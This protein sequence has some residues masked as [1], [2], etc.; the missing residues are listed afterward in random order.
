[1]RLYIIADMEGV[2]GITHRD[3]LMEDGGQ[4]YW[5]GC[6]LLTGDINAV[7]EGA[8][9]EGV[10][11]VLV[12]EGH[13]NMRNVLVD[14]LHPAA[15]VLRGPARWDT[16][17]LCQV[18][19]LTSDFDLAMFVGFHSRAGTPKGLLCHTW[20]SAVVHKITLNGREVGE[21]AI[22]AAIL[23]DA[24]V[25]VALVCG[26]DDLAREA[27]ADLGDV[28]TAVVKQVHGFD[29]A[30][31]WGPKRTAPLLHGAAATAVQR[32]RA[33]DFAPF[34][35]EGPVTAEITV[36]NDA[37]ADRMS[38]VPGVERVQRRKLRVS[39]ATATDALSAAWRGV[40]EVFH[41]PAGWMR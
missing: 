4:R 13:A 16:K 27:T 26:G 1:M 8:V 12:S 25:P 15:R 21:T 2:T 37:M 29:L 36:L 19:A 32:H 9:S 34:V 39:G 23:G 20:A 10:T 6:A 18:G 40:S 14:Q 31:C 17:P 41:E 30:S 35:I 5:S 11:D 28:Q 24:G 22:N 33:G 3:Q 7:I 38:L